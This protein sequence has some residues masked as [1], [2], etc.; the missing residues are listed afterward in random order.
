M[1]IK[2]Y[3][4]IRG[5]ESELIGEGESLYEAVENA[6]ESGALDALDELYREVFDEQIEVLATYILTA[7][8]DYVVTYV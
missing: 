2:L 5:K 1:T 3:K 8:Q 6:Y 7:Q 4:A